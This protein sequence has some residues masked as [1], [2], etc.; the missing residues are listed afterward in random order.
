[1]PL[2]LNFERKYNAANKRLD[3]TDTDAGIMT[4]TKNKLEM[5]ILQI[6]LYLCKKIKYERL[7]GK[8][9]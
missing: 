2:N 6:K 9:E 3:A 8:Q 4:G 7:I 5:C 1:M